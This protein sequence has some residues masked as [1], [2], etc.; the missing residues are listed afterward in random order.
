VCELEA[1]PEVS[2]ERYKFVA[3]AGKYGQTYK[4]WIELM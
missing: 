3:Y 1:I 2:A 4:S